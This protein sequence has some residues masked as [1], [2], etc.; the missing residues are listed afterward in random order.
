M[1]DIEY[2]LARLTPPV[3][4]NVAALTTPH[5]VDADIA[6]IERSF[7]DEVARE[8]NTNRHLR[9]LR[10]RVEVD[11]HRNVNRAAAQYRSYLDIP[12]PHH[13]KAL[14][15][16]LTGEHPLLDVRGGWAIRGWKIAPEWRLLR[17][18]AEDVEDAIHALFNCDA[19][20]DLSHLRHCFWND[21]T[22][23]DATLRGSLQDLAHW[24]RQ[25]CMQPVTRTAARLARLAFNI[26]QLDT[27]HKQ[28][29]PPAG[30]VDQDGHLGAETWILEG[31]LF[32]VHEERPGSDGSSC[33]GDFLYNSVL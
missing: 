21:V 5:R 6:D 23:V 24:V 22:A 7:Q 1:G 18:C 16:M 19:H 12:T 17:F 32:M 25:L 15:L 20:A 4:V 8:I 2:G 10:G 9:L 30:G 3:H 14:T 29:N 27:L 33:N 11:R 31:Q 13:R 26:L 28:F